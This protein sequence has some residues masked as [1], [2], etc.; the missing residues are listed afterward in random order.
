MRY[1][2]LIKE[3]YKNNIKYFLLLYFNNLFCSI[4]LASRINNSHFY[5][6]KYS[7][8]TIFFFFNFIFLYIG[9]CNYLLYIL[10]SNSLF[11]IKYNIIQRIGKN[12]L[13]FII[14]I[15]S[16]CTCMFIFLTNI[17]ID[18]ILVKD[19]SIY[20]LFDFFLNLFLFCCF[21]YSQK[22]VLPYILCFTLRCFIFYL[23]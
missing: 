16:L 3:F 10:I 17:S 23:M 22:T 4:Y 11:E 14:L 12:R 6:L 18:Y 19:I 8:Q 5:L 7:Y 13:Q 9:I 2:T 1:I 21:S 20:T 15:Y